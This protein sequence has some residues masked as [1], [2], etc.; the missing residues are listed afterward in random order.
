MSE[1][2]SER[3]TVLIVDDHEMVR[4]GL[5]AFL[6]ITPDLELVGEASSGEEA[7]RISEA[8]KPDVI[9]MDMMMPGI[10]GATATRQIRQRCPESQ[11][12]VLTSFPEEDLLQ[13]ALEAGALGYLLKNVGASE[14]G[15]AIRAA[16][17][18][19]PTLAAEATQLLIQRAT[20]PPAPGHDLSPREREVLKLMTQGLSNRSIA[21]KLVISPSTADFHV[22]N[23]LGKLGVSSR[24]EAVALAVQ[25]RLVE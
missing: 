16:K 2:G 24:T 1:N 22:S 3:I 5:A 21:D 12:L 9:L 4:R 10:D 13:K 19:R 8:K 23:I 18:G 7:I 20:R 11:V 6:Q 14:L 15:A 17:A 25:N